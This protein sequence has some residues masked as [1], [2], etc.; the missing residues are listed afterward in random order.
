MQPFSISSITNL[1]SFHYAVPTP[2][3]HHD[4]CHA[5]GIRYCKCQT[6]PA[7]AHG[8]PCEEDH[9]LYNLLDHNEIRLS[10]PHKN[11]DTGI[12]TDTD[13]ASSLAPTT[14]RE[15][16]ERQLRRDCVHHVQVVIQVRCS[17]FQ[18]VSIQCCNSARRETIVANP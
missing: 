11:D 9:H 1:E 12:D 14:T 10:F 7:N 16:N 4:S 18:M 15:T 2:A 5:I 6:G 13:P 8:P 3:R 17:N